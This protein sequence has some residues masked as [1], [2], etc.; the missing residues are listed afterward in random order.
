MSYGTACPICL[1]T[2]I[3]LYDIGGYKYLFR[4]TCPKGSDGNRWSLSQLSC[5]GVDSKA[6]IYDVSEVMTVTQ[7]E[8]FKQYNAKFLEKRES[9]TK[10]IDM[11]KWKEV[12]A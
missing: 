2:G 9:V 3:H 12:G 11:S 4:C 7:I 10:T 8:D 6:Y 5:G 1:N